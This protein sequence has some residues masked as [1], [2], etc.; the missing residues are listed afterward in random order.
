MAAA[1]LWSQALDELGCDAED[2]AAPL[3]FPSLMEEEVRK[4]TAQLCSNLAMMLVDENRFAEGLRYADAAVKIE[5]SNV[6]ALFRGACAHVGLGDLP[7]AERYLYEA[8]S[9]GVYRNSPEIEQKLKEV[10]AAQASRRS[11]EAVRQAVRARCAD[12]LVSACKVLANLT[13]YGDDYEARLQALVQAGA[14][15]ALVAAEHEAARA[16]HMGVLEQV[17]RALTNLALVKDA[18]AVQV[19]VQAGAA[20]VLVSEAR[21]AVRHHHM[22]MGDISAV[23]RRSWP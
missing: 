7:T 11:V 14:A 18:E 6:K 12:D 5:P 17:S 16:G 1:L 4:L 10:Q 21:W 20:P 15:A 8:K 19:L 22:G 13:A 9:S 23:P 2:L 3:D